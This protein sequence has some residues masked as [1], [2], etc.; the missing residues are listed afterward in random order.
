V[1]QTIKWIILAGVLTVVTFFVVIFWSVRQP[2]IQH[3][4]LERVSLKTGYSIHTDTGGFQVGVSP[5]L[6]GQNVR[7]LDSK[8]KE[9]LSAATLGVTPRLLSL[10]HPKTGFS[11]PGTVEAADV[12]FDVPASGTQK[13]QQ[14]QFQ[15]IVLN[16]SYSISQKR[17]DISS[18]K[19]I[20]PDTSV[21]ARGHIQTSAK[22]VTSVEVDVSAPSMP[23][24]T[25]KTLLPEPLLP[26][27]LTTDLLPAITQGDVRLDHFRLDGTTEQIAALDKPENAPVLGLNLDMQHLR[28]QYPAGN[29]ITLEDAACKLAIDKGALSIQDISSH[30]GKSVIHRASVVIP[31]LYADKTQYQTTVDADIAAADVMRLQKC[32]LIPP[33]VR[34]QLQKISG[35]DGAANVHISFD[36][37]SGQKVP[38]FT[39]GA[40]SIQ[41]LHLTHPDLRLP[42]TISKA[43]ITVDT[44]QHLRFNGN[45]AWGK[46]TFTAQGTGDIPGETFSADISALGD[47]PELIHAMFPSVAMTGWNY[48]PLKAEGSA[49][50]S[51]VTVKNAVQ[52]VGKGYVEFKGHQTFQPKPDTNWTG[53]IHIVQEPAVNLMQIFLPGA[54]V[55]DGSVSIE[56]M[57][58]LKNSDDSGKFSGLSGHAKLLVEKGWIS[59]SSAILKILD[60]IS[61]QR[62]YKPGDPGLLEKRIYFDRLSGDLEIEKGKIVIKDLIL[63]SPAINAAGAGVIDLNRGDQIQM[64]IGLQPLGTVDSIVSKIPLIGHILTGKDHA[65]VVYYVDVTGS[66]KNPDIHQVPL[67]NIGETTLGYLERLVFTPERI[68]NSLTAIPK[69]ISETWPDYRPEFEQTAP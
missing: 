65:L 5:M 62:L 69:S 44:P 67:Q 15:K 37:A 7:V 45:G 43:D 6:Q 58:F 21:T 68:L 9:V 50:T 8:N 16:G 30:F 12:R 20:A 64:K 1:I 22:G 40:V 24:G 59:Q 57:I 41:S 46:S 55:L 32:S 61:L 47:T 42:L 11:I 13:A 14:C 28:V 34:L 38:T 18:L 56:G 51:G 31:N 54:H 27:W 60:V 17:F 39:S 63:K 53:H 49:V 19:L 10:I 2:S 25:F 35:L 29:G 4:M 66:L 33:D 52:P 36:A 48:G 3:Y 26:Q 23:V